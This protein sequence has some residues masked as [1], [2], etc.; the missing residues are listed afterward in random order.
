M[1]ILAL[2]LL[3][4]PV[5]G[6]DVL[7]SIKRGDAAYADFRTR[8]A[9]TFYTQ[10]YKTDS[11]DFTTLARL[12]RTWSDL[13]RLTLRRSDSS[14]IYYRTAL[15]YA[16]QLTS[17]HPDSASSWFLLALCHGSLTPF[18]SLTEKLD[19]AQDV[20]K[21]ALRSLELDSAYSMT[22]VLLGI[23][24]RGV[25]QLGWVERTIVNGI[26]GKDIHGTIED[27]ERNLRKAL[28]LDPNNSFAYYELSRT[29]RS[30]GREAESVEALRKVLAFAPA[31]EREA[32]QYESAE[33]RLERMTSG[34]ASGRSR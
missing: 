21:N 9:L 29:L 30:A 13:G 5:S 15:S 31:N 25:S 12:A 34:T 3:F 7:S 8:D 16:R 32:Q 1:L 28:A 6:D 20:E 27:S 17:C 23:Y 22:Y 2:L 24:Y 19:I 4:L 11:T 26:L 18:K 14:E 33:R 10:A